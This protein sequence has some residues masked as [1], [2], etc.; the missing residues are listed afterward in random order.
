MLR[1]EKRAD[2]TKPQPLKI[3][4]YATRN[5]NIDL[6]LIKQSNITQIKSLASK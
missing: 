6:K 4:V 5:I 1:N 2:E 3:S